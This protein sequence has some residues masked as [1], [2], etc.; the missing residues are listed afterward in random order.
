MKAK[1]ETLNISC[2]MIL[3]TGIQYSM[4]ESLLKARSGLPPVPLS[5]GHGAESLGAAKLLCRGVLSAVLTL[6]E[7]RLLI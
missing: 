2:E 3:G 5:T 7:I 6:Q 4:K 1:K